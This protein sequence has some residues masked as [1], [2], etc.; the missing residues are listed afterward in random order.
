[1]KFHGVQQSEHFRSLRH[2]YNEIK[3]AFVIPAIGAVR[4]Y[5]PVSTDRH[6]IIDFFIYYYEKSER[7]L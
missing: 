5:S 6:G 1:M 4:G 2:I 7:I 3:Q